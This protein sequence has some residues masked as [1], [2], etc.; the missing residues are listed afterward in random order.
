MTASQFKEMRVETADGLSLYLRD[1]L[2]AFRSDRVPVVCLHGLTRNGKDF[3]AVA[4]WLAQQG[5]RV[6]VPDMRGR[7]R[8]D[9]DPEPRRYKVTTYAEDVATILIRLGIPRAVFIGTSMGGLITMAMAG[10]HRQRIVGA[11]LND[12][13]PLVARAG[14][15]RIKSYAGKTIGPSDWASA[16]R[17]L[18][19]INAGQFPDYDDEDWKRLARMTFTEDQDGSPVPDYDPAVARPVASLRLASMIAWFYFRR[20]GRHCPTLL[21]RGE[22]SDLLSLPIAERMHRAA[23]TMTMVEVPRVGHAPMLT[24]PVARAAIVKF[25]ERVG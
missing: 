13:G 12:I 18:R 6:I 4:P 21:L 3:G 1:Y 22:M 19:T 23:P 24:E 10:R 17:Y 7:G 8:S 5:R 16:E 14:I 25:L 2:P 20:L 9:R 11:V 15:D